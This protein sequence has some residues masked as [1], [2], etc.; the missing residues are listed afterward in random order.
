MDELVTDKGQHNWIKAVLALLCAKLVLLPFM[1]KQCEIQYSNS[2]TCVNKFCKLSTYSCNTCVIETLKPYHETNSCPL[3]ARYR[4]GIKHCNCMTKK[5]IACPMDSSCSVLYDLILKDHNELE[6]KWTNSECKKWY[7]NG[8]EQLK[9]FIQIPGYKDRINIEDA[10]ITAYV[11]ICVNNIKIRQHLGADLD[12][13]EKVRQDRNDIFHSGTCSLPDESLKRVVANVKDMLKM[14][15]LNTFQSEIKSQ[16]DVLQKLE[17]FQIEVNV[18]HEIQAHKEALR[19]INE[20]MQYIK[21]C[22]H[23]NNVN[24]DQ[25]RVQVSQLALQEDQH[26]RFIKECFSK[27]K[28]NMDTMKLSY[29]RSASVLMEHLKDVSNITQAVSSKPEAYES[30]LKELV[31]CKQGICGLEVVTRDI[32]DTVKSNE[33]TT[34]ETNACV[35]RM[36]LEM[37]ELKTSLQVNDIQVKQM[38]NVQNAGG[39]CGYT[40]KIPAAPLHGSL[41]SPRIPDASLQY[42]NGKKTRFREYDVNRKNRVIAEKKSMDQKSMTRVEKEKQHKPYQL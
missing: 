16:F 15:T 6:P 27:I 39:K 9:C 7:L 5:T 11:Q 22:T 38:A 13:L 41:R 8:W 33:K 42:R 10:D 14:R 37:E 18:G 29:E 21:E 28:R 26:M 40:V 25:L 4:R 35:K 24:T 3:R 2:K 12:I 19:Y 34:S 32:H 30:L 31:E 23:T 1:K 20:T 36:L 17:Q